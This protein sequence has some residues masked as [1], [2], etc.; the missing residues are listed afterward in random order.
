MKSKKEVDYRQSTPEAVY[1][2]KKVALKLRKTTKTVKEISEITGLSDQTVRNLFKKYD[3]GGLSAIK[4]RKRGRRTGEK[5]TLTHAQEK[6]I[7]SLIVDKNPE[8]LKLKGWMW[9]RNSVKELIKQKYEMDMPIRTVGEYLKRWGLTV[10]RPAK[11]EMNQ[12]SEQI[13]VWLEE[14]YPAIHAQA[15]SENAEI[16]WGDETA[17]QNVANYVRGY[18]PKGHTPVVK[19]QSK[20]MH[21]NMISAINNQ[22]KLHF[23]LYSD[24]INSERLISF[25]EAIIKTAQG[26]KVYL[27][28][29]NLRVHHSKRVTEWVEEHKA[30][31]SLFHLPPYAPEYNPDEYLNNDLKHSIGTQSAVKTVGELE[32]HANV[33]MQGLS[34]N[35]KHV[36][37]HFD[38]PS[39]KGYKLD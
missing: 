2:L 34:D 29:D 20:K 8:Q 32:D 10:Q 38:H 33:F 11:Q 23:L 6:E 24:A 14:Q 12:K 36:Q 4:P 7:L 25:M 1:E 9:T 35:P 30:Q 16:F 17:V 19:Y 31:I 18:A 27:I 28:L 37:S 26:R 5:R 15:K 21:I 3:E 22:G 13:D 39:L